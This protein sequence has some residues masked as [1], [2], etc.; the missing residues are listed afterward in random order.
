MTRKT[1]FATCLLAAGLAATA[2][3]CGRTGRPLAGSDPF[4]PGG[5]VAADIRIRVRNQNF[6]DASLTA[7]S[8]TGERRLGNVGGNSSAVFTTPWSFTSSLRI[9]IDLL[10]GPSCVTDVITVSPGETVNLDIP[11]DFRTA[12]TCR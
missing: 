8:D 5:V 10:A 6:Y 11:P 3:A 9:Q 2:T 1:R 4:A 7:I 12:T